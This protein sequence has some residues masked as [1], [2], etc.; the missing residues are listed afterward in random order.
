ML[1][2]TFKMQTHMHRTL[3]W[4]LVGTVRIYKRYSGLWVRMEWLNVKRSDFLS[5]YKRYGSY[6][7]DLCLNGNVL[8]R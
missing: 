2:E 1:Q 5:V 6:W 4:H 8:M 3:E 7:W